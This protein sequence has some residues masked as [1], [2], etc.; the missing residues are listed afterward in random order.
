[1]ETIVVCPIGTDLA[2][3]QSA[4]LLRHD[5]DSVLLAG[6]KVVVDLSCVESIS[7]SYADELFG[8]LALS[9]GLAVFS[10]NV[11]IRGASSDV[12]RRVAGAIKERLGQSELE[13]TL[14]TLVAAKHA[15]GR[16][17]SRGVA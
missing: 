16:R 4:A 15:C 9:G 17:V 8:V 5:I 13:R 7:E 2:S 6:D 12:L 14:Q 10:A 1:M 11:L 3:R